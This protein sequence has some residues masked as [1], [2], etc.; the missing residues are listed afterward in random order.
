M[1]ENIKVYDGE[2]TEEVL[3]K[4]VVAAES[5]HSYYPFHQAGDGSGFKYSWQIYFPEA[6]INEFTSPEIKALWGDVQKMLPE[7]SILRKCYVN[8]HQYGVEDTIH[9]DD[10]WFGKGKTVIVY[11]CRAWYPD[12]GGATMFFSGQDRTSPIS[13]MD[14]EK[15][16]LPKY[17]RLVMFDKDIYHCAGLVSRRFTGLRLT[18]M[19]KVETP[20]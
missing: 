14:I 12:W 3:Q 13:S 5:S 6:N 9:Q 1:L 19:F 11:L 2:I 7:G 8:A 18:C 16:V 15:C 17:N 4:A 10:I 20:T